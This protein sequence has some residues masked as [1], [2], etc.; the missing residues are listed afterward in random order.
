MLKS[1]S[2]HLGCGLVFTLMHLSVTAQQNLF[3]NYQMGGLSS[4]EFTTN[5]FTAVGVGINNRIWAGTNYNG[6]YTFDPGFNI[7]RKSSR[8][9]NVFINHILA[10][11]DGGIWIGQSGTLTQS[12]NSNIAGGV[13]YF[14]TSSDISMSFYSVQG[15]TTGAFLRS[16]NVRSLFVDPTKGSANNSNPGVWAAQGSFTTSFT[17]TK[18]GINYG[19]YTVQPFFTNVT[20]GLS[21]AANE[22][23]NCEAIGGNDK[24]VWV[25]ARPNNSKA[26]ILRYNRQSR[27]LIGVIDNTN[28]SLLGSSFFTRAIFFDNHGYAWIGF[29]TNGLIVRK[30]DNSWERINFPELLS[31]AAINNNAIAQDEFGNVYI[32]TNTGLLRFKSPL[33][34][35]GSVPWLSTSYE[36][37]TTDNG[38]PS[39]NITGLAYDALHK[40]MILA[41]SGGVS[42]MRIASPFIE[43]LAADFNMNPNG[44]T[45]PGYDLKPLPIGATINLYDDAD[46]EL[47]EVSE[48]IGKMPFKLVKAENNKQ[49][50]VEIKA[51]GTDNDIT[52]LYYDL[53]N[54]TL[55]RPSNFP[56]A[57]MKALKALKPKMETKDIPIEL[58]GI[59]VNVPIKAGFKTAGF[60][61]G[62]H[63]YSPPAIIT[64]D[65]QKILENL[66]EYYASLYCVNNLG[67]SSIAL[68]NEAFAAIFPLIEGLMGTNDMIEGYEDL[69]ETVVPGSTL[70][71]EKKDTKK[72]LVAQIKLARSTVTWVVKKIYSFNKPDEKTQKILEYMAAMLNDALDILEKAAETYAQEGGDPGFKGKAAS[73]IVQ[74]NLKKAITSVFTIL[75]YNYYAKVVHDDFIPKASFRSATVAS[76]KTFAYTYARLLEQGGTSLT[77]QTATL[78]KETKENIELYKK[79]SAIADYTSQVLDA[80]TNLKF[81]PSGQAFSA[82]FKALS[83]ASKFVKLVATATSVAE[84][85]V[86][87]SK[88]IDLSEKILETPEPGSVLTTG[89]NYSQAGVKN[90]APLNVPVTLTNAAHAYKASLTGLKAVYNGS[91]ANAQYGNRLRAMQAADST[92]T[93]ELQFAYNSIWAVADSASVYIPGFGNQ[94]GMLLDSFNLRFEDIRR[95]FNY[96]NLAFIANPADDSLRTS[97]QAEADSIIWVCDSLLNR[98]GNFMG[99][100]TT[101]TYP[102]TGYLAQTGKTLI[103]S[104]VPGSSGSVSYTFKNFGQAPVT[105]V[106]FKLTELTGGYQLATPDSLLAGNIAPGGTCTFSFSFTSPMHDSLGKYFITV[107]AAQGT[108]NDVSGSLFV[109]E[110]GKYYTVQS[111]NWHHATTWHS[112]TVPDANTKVH[113]NHPVVVAE[114]AACK[115]LTTSPGVN[116]E[117][118]PG[119][120]LEIRQ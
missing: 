63:K 81:L 100:L 6:L 66:A 67:D 93:A 79:I 77:G 3:T 107:E 1:I 57:L 20:Q 86:G 30:P 97:M 61:Y 116:I 105:Q 114:N 99:M 76:D 65:H 2:W 82:A 24:E 4:E 118:K 32:G 53:P 115:T 94:L 12:G 68:L 19:L 36:K 48:L 88:V 59:R 9:T 74:A 27:A 11:P 60:E 109:I 29:S 31:G 83:L 10:D 51:R 73:G 91:V 26:Q 22:L 14:P 50:N 7:W 23:T 113:L 78:T 52:Y 28:N 80:G 112:G 96:S 16:R 92:L 64:Q 43:G 54:E 15:T 117:V 33:Y 38:L 62:W 85:V 47:V 87:G 13:N 120:K 84:G 71:I 41:T 119:K 102:A 75:A 25:A 72:L 21:T 104:L 106:K 55:L 40:R 108:T 5:S 58:S 18:G 70:G 8:L 17:A 110:P 35:P 45:L 56:F 111:G 103:H 37:Y 44:E 42:F 89:E 90:L 98:L 69:L 101:T 95:P 46:G 39:N 49:Y 34:N